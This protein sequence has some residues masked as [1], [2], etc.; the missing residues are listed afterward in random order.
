MRKERQLWADQNFIKVLNRIKAKRML[1]GKKESLA[2]I[3]GM[4]VNLPSFQDVERQLT[5]EQKKFMRFE[6]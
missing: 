4:M 6:N 5:D 3:T 1:T 2:D